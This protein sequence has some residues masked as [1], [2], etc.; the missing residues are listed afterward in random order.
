MKIHR[1]WLLL[2]DE[3]PRIGSGWRPVD[4]SIGR[5]WVHIK[6]KAGK[7]KITKG[8]WGALVKTMQRYHQRNGEG[9]LNTFV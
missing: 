7:H 5:R 3:L 4:V 6:S 8:A 1:H 2:A 9:P